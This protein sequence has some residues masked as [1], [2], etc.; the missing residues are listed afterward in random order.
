MGVIVDV[1]QCINLAGGTASDVTM[2]RGYTE[3]CSVSK[4]TSNELLY[5]KLPLGHCPP[6]SFP[7]QLL[8]NCEPPDNY[9]C[10]NY[11]GKGTFFFIVTNL[12]EPEWKRDPH[13]VPSLAARA[14]VRSRQL[15]GRAVGSVPSILRSS[16]RLHA[17][18]LPVG[19]GVR[20]CYP[21]PSRP[22]HRG[23]PEGFVPWHGDR[24]PGRGI[25]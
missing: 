11:R 25:A 10:Y 1:D 2:V 6:V 3:C 12:S 13:A 21:N 7:L 18:S 4:G 17:P 15:W 16:S 5:S 14:Q 23:K 20:A 8:R 9:P 24:A 19:S 22:A